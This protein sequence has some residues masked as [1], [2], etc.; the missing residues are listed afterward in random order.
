MLTNH[1]E[2]KKILKDAAERGWAF[3]KG[4]GRH[5]KGKHTTGKTATI[6]V[7]PSDYRVLMNIQKDLRV[8]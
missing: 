4:R 3:T 7:S 5:I 2:L 8:G 6:S 1:K